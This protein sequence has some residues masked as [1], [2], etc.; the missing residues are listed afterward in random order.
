M[1]RAVATSIVCTMLLVM[2]T[3]FIV[4]NARRANAASVTTWYGPYL[5]RT[6]QIYTPAAGTFRAGGNLQL[7]WGASGGCWLD[8]VRKP[9]GRVITSGVVCYSSGTV[10]A[11]TPAMPPCGSIAVVLKNAVAVVTEQVTPVC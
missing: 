5:T 10:Y 7:S 1:K 2:A 6:Y 4:P 9:N 3:A 11:T 8:T